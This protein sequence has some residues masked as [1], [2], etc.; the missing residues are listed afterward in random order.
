MDY[1]ITV[2]SFSLGMLESVVVKRSVE[3]LADTATITLPGT[4]YNRTLEV[5]SKIEEG[6]RVR[7]CFGYDGRQVVLP[8][9][10]E[11]YVD[12][13]ATDDGSI[14]IHCEDELYTLRRAL[15]DKAFKR[16]SVK[17]LLEHVL[18]ELKGDFS[19]ACDYEFRYDRFTIRQA[20]AY[21]VLKKL[22]EETRANI[23]LRGSTLH[24]HPQ[25]A[26]AGREVIYDFAVNIEKSE[27][28][29]KDARQRKVLVTVEGTDEKGKPVR[30]QQG[31]PGGDTITL[32]LPG[33][34]D[35]ATLSRRAVEEVSIRTYT[36]YEGSFTGW[37]LPQIEPADQVVLRDADYATKNGTYY[38]V[39]VET[40]FSAS[41]G[42]RKITLGKTI[43]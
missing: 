25:Y 31:M 9:E 40:S 6:D 4:Q 21:D 11:G 14:R 15:K 38:A 1:D 13:I 34:S 29:Y 32:R 36:G 23:Y 28:K 35:P 17:E 8:V 2:G 7:I 43:G 33:V 22:Q 20:T 19:L 24:I 16:V 37:L 26:D 5:E 39:A 41:G 3:T 12:S 10:F 27:L 30:A 18:G 42:S